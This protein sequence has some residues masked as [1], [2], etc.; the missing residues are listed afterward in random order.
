M[1]KSNTEIYLNTL[2]TCL[3]HPCTANSHKISYE[4]LGERIRFNPREHIKGVS[5][6][7]VKHELEWY[8]SQDRCIKGHAGIENNKV[9]QS[10]A[11]EHGIVNSNYGWCIYS[12]QNGDQFEHVVRAIVNDRSTKQACMY[13]TR[14]TIHTECD[15]GIN[16][17]YD[18]ICTCYTSSLLRDGKLEHHVHMRS[19]DIW[20][21]LRND[22]AWQQEV[23]R[24]LI[25]RL[26][27][28]G[29]KCEEGDIVWFADSLHLYERNVED[30]KQ[31]IADMEEPISL[32]IKS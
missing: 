7:Y 12:H 9:W 6:E 18:M 29:V 30:V 16:A 20:F 27:E 2:Y 25:A 5:E 19:N 24:R 1:R 17:K 14:P 3:Q 31:Y 4:L 11:T 13:Y 8:D 26:N 32:D 10:C 21:G 22:L 15:D 23:Q 28:G